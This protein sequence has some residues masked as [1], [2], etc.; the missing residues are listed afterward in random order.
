[1]RA[2]LPRS[3]WLGY[4]APVVAVLAWSA[5]ARADAAG[6]KVLAS[7]D[8]SLN[9]AKTQFIEYEGITQEPG[10]AERK[11]G[12]E[13]RMKGEKRLSEFLAPADMKGTKVL[14][15]STT[16][17]YVY[18]PAFGKIRR[19]ASHT[20]DQGFMGMTFSQDDFALTKYSDSYTA[21]VASETPSQWKLTATPKAGQ[22]TA[23]SKLEITVAKDKTVP[24]EIRYFNAG[25]THSKTE[26]RTDYTCEG[27]I[28]NPRELKMT[29]HTK[30]GH[31]TKLIR[32]KWKV[33]EAMSDDLFSK[34][35]LQP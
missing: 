7:L 22:T 19:I 15:L 24:T 26:T 2:L 27:D 20:T 16:Q 23:Y 34:R 5:T 13:I 1:M 18:L 25:G 29:D 3:R 21:T 10:K 14:I 31:W 11:L 33:N 9:R 12:L 4:A 32:K 28:C 6:D 30:G 35:S 17:M 8:T